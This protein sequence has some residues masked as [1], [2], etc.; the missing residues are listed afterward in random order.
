MDDDD[1]VWSRGNRWLKLT[2][3]IVIGVKKG[4]I[5]HWFLEKQ[6]RKCYVAPEKFAQ[7]FKLI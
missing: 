2:K 1:V 5:S 4:Q 3:E 7:H 6:I